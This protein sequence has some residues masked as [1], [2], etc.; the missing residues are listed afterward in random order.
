MSKVEAGVNLYQ[1]IL[2]IYING[3]SEDLA[4]N[5]KLFADGTSLFSVV[6]NVDAS[7]IDLKA[8]VCY[9][10]SNFIFW[11]NDSLLRTMKN[12]FCFI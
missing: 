7:S 9:F 2:S 11:P 5:A 3:L 8:C 12:V 4:W 10:L 6:K 1:S